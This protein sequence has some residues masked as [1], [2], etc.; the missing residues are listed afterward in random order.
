MSLSYRGEAQVARSAGLLFRNCGGA[1]ICGM[2]YL[3]QPPGSASQWVP[4]QAGR[5]F[6]TF[7]S[8][9]FIFPPTVVL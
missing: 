1:L 9:A 8:A 2:G 6:G 5:S 7:R 3:A 4:V